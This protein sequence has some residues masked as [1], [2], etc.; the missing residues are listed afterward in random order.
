MVTTKRKL[1]GTP[2]G[3]L[4]RLSNK[5]LSGGLVE[6]L[7]R[8]EEEGYDDKVCD[9][10]KDVL[11]NIYNECK[12]HAQSA[13]MNEIVLDYGDFEQ[14]YHDWNGNG[15]SK[16]EDAILDRRE[17]IDK[18]RRKIRSWT[19]ETYNKHHKRNIGSDASIENFCD[20]VVKLLETISNAHKKYFTNLNGSIGAYRKYVGLN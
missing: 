5:I 20:E 7:N 16:D 9:L 2:Q 1:S 11:T 4:Y 18:L 8:L 15:T 12:T 17:K 6:D 14:L 19:K 3:K 13:W 10:V